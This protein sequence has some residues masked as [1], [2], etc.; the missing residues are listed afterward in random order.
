MYSTTTANYSYFCT[1]GEF[2]INVPS[3]LCFTF[4]H[5]GAVSVRSYTLTVQWKLLA[6]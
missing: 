5:L 2:S 4:S 1:K 3:Y 6:F